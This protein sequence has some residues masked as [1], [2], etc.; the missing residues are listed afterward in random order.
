MSENLL[1]EITNVNGKPREDIESMLGLVLGVLFIMPRK[2]VSTCSLL[3]LYVPL[4]TEVGKGHRNVSAA[5][6]LLWIFTI[7]YCIA[8]DL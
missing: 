5:R 4:I 3:S 6:I 8:G 2:C 1:N 7:L